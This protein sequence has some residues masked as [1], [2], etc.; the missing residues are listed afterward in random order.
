MG[1][2][3]VVVD[4]GTPSAPFPITVLFPLEMTCPPEEF[5][6]PVGLL[7]MRLRSTKACPR[8]PSARNPTVPLPLEVEDWRERTAEALA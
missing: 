8:A 5:V 1:Y 7:V 3:R 6:R 2:F 4:V